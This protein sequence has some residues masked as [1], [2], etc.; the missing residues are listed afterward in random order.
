MRNRDNNS[1]QRCHQP[2]FS[3]DVDSGRAQGSL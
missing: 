2:R 3:D 1:D